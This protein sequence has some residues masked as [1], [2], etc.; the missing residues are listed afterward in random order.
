MVPMGD[1]LQEL[2]DPEDIQRVKRREENN[3]V[4]PREGGIVRWSACS[5]HQ[6]VVSAGRR[7]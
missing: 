4:V 1:E 6:R 5:L 7:E 2:K 3:T